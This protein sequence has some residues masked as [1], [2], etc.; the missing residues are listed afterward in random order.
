MP[1][2][3]SALEGAH[4]SE[5]NEA[6]SYR[7]LATNATTGLG[8]SVFRK[9]AQLNAARLRLTPAR[10]S[11]LGAALQVFFITGLPSRSSPRQRGKVKNVRLR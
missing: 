8:T 7:Q 11:S 4:A 10:Q 1:F 3:Q 2:R 5:Q 9:F 6:A